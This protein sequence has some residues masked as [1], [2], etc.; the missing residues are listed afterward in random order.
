MLREGGENK[1]KQQ[2]KKQTNTF[3]S[4]KVFVDRLVKCGLIDS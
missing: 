1:K 2:E 4:A 3:L